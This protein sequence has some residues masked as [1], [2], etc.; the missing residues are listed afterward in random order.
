MVEI[1]KTIPGFSKYMLSDLG[2]IKSMYPHTRSKNK[3][4]DGYGLVWVG[5]SSSKLYLRT[6]LINDENERKSC[7]LS[8]LLYSTFKGII[9]NDRMVDHIDG[10][11]LNN[12]LDNLRLV[13]SS[14]SVINQKT[15]A[16]RKYK[17]VSLT[18]DNKWEARTSLNGKMVYL[19]R[20][21]SEQEAHQRFQS[22]AKET[23]GEYCRD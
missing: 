5:L 7:I 23:Y 3:T 15:R 22:F 2:R 14:Q 13:N 21:N 20:F 19:G 17:G 10:N 16:G 6:C 8:R 12:S 18:R 9:P 11:T 1:W 4:E